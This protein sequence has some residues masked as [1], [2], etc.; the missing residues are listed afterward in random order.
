MASSLHAVWLRSKPASRKRMSMTALLRRVTWWSIAPG[1][2]AIYGRQPLYFEEG[3]LR[4]ARRSRRQNTHPLTA[5]FVM[6]FAAVHARWLVFGCQDH[7]G[8]GMIALSAFCSIT[9]YRRANDKGISRS[10]ESGVMGLFSNLCRLEFIL[11]VI[12]R[13]P[14]PPEPRRLKPALDIAGC[15]ALYTLYTWPSPRRRGGGRSEF[16]G[17]LYGRDLYASHLD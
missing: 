16:T 8:T 1:F 2:P 4:P 15:L 10:I 5:V 17:S 9:S 13:M 14:M 11:A 3:P 6:L 12:I 7:K